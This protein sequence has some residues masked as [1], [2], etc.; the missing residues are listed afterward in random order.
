MENY[1]VLNAAFKKNHIMKI[2]DVDKLI[3]ARYQDNLEFCQWIKKYHDIKN[4]G[5]DYDAVGRRN[6]QQM[7]YILGGNKVHA[8]PKAGQAAR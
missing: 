3:K 2:P 4:T 5:E 6:G 7:H 1:K 8:M